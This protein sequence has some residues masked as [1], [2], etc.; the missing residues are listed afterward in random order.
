M[1]DVAN[2]IFQKVDDSSSGMPP[3]TSAIRENAAEAKKVIEKVQTNNR[4]SWLATLGK[5]WKMRRLNI[6]DNPKAKPMNYSE[7]LKAEKVSIIDLSDTDSPEIN[8]MAIAQI[9]RGIQRAQEAAVKEAGDKK[10]RPIPV[11]VIIEEAHE[12]LSS[13]RIKQMPVLFQQVAKIAKRGRKRW[14]GLTFVTQLPQHLPNE[15]LALINN[16]ILHKISDSGVVDRLRKSISGLDKNQW[17]TV[18]GLASGQAV[19]SITSMAKPLMV[20]V[21]P[22]PCKLHFID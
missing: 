22:T 7:L 5:L 20:S 21:H 18:P 10:H 2:L 1:I 13:E 6:F 19:V 11:N 9:L 14:L 3:M 17:G 12:F 8:N 4:I 15:V 16:F